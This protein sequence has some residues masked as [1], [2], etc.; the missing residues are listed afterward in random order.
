[1]QGECVA[2]PTDGL[3][4]ADLYSSLPLEQV[5]DF[6]MLLSSARLLAGTLVWIGVLR[7]MVQSLWVFIQQALQ[8]SR[9]VKH[10]HHPVPNRLLVVFALNLCMAMAYEIQSTGDGLVLKG[11]VTSLFVVWEALYEFL[12]GFIGSRFCYINLLKY[13]PQSAEGPSRTVVRDSTYSRLEFELFQKIVL[14]SR[15]IQGVD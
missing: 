12:F 6:G 4:N 9:S 8:W 2:H 11:N 1:M 7:F 3:T 14:I 13:F 10:Q 5:I 15:V